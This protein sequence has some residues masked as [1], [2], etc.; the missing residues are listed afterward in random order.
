MI[1]QWRT[2][3]L[4]EFAS[5][6]S[7]GPFGSILHKSDYV[8]CG[9]PLVNPINIVGDRIVPDPKKLIGS[10]TVARLA[11]YI[12]KAGDIVVGRRGEIGRCAVVGPDEGGWICGTGCF[13]IR[14]LP[15]IDPHFIARLIGS[16]KYREKLVRAATGSTMLNLSNTTLGNLL[17]SVPPLEDQRRIV[18]ILDRAASI[19]RLQRQA[20]ETACQNVPALFNRLFGDPGSNPMGWPLV[21]V[22][23]VANVQ[24]G[25][26]VTAARAGL[27]LELPYLRVANVMR[28]SLNLAEV[29]TIRLTSNERERARLEAG[30]LL[31]VEGHGNP[32]EV[33]RVAVWDGSIQDCVHQNHLIRIRCHDACRPHFLSSYLN[34]EVGR[35]G[36]I[37]SGKTTSGLNTISTANVKQAEVF[38]PPIDLQKEFERRVDDFT[39]LT[40]RQRA[41]AVACDAAVQAIQSRLFSA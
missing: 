20:Q 12:L 29:K 33:G 34:S 19:R 40:G 24:G 3:P 39:R 37:R 35:Q 28:N 13:F 6:V 7:T 1:S 9:V 25:L 14:P 16:E 23:D 38:L 4:A 32:R 18:D 27:P 17:V 41:A 22:A 36:L 2:A 21:T 8:K 10:Q 26:Q 11:S 5:L 31:V 30:D 15:T